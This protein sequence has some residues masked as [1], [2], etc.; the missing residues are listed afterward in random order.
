M[1]KRMTMAAL[2][3]VAASLLSTSAMAN[4]ELAKA[5]GCLACHKVSEKLVGPAY[6]DIAAKY[7]GNKAAPA[8]LAEKVMKGGV[9]AWGQVPMPPNN[10]TADEA[11]KLVA[12]VLSLK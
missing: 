2:A 11:K 1:K 7:K 10:V 9:G 5:K 12:W 6:K 3:M 4:E 8:K